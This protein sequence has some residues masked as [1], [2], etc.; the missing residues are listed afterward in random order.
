MPSKL[1]DFPCLRVYQ[2]KRSFLHLNCPMI[3]FTTF[4]FGSRFHHPKNI[5]QCSMYR[6]FN[7]YIICNTYLI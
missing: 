5:P 7:I 4:E 1:V 2:V 3:R 6:I